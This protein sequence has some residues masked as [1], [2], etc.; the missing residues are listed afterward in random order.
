MTNNKEKAYLFRLKHTFLSC[1]TESKNSYYSLMA[2]KQKRFP[3]FVGE[4][5]LPSFHLTGKRGG[6]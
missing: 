1:K 3:I 2:F 6:E 5:L 4:P